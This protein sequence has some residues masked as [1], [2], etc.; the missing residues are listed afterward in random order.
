M[1]AVK[2]FK[3]PMEDLSKSER[4]EAKTEIEVLASLEHP[5][6]VRFLERW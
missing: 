6:I 1:V 5:S 2:K 3:V 4:E